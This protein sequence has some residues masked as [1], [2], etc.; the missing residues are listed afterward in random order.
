[1]ASGER[2]AELKPWVVPCFALLVVGFWAM[3]APWPRRV[4]RVERWIDR[5]P[6]KERLRSLDRA[7]VNYA[8]HPVEMARA[9]GLPLATHLAIAGAIHVLARAYGGVLSY[10]D[11]VAV[12]SVANTVS[13]VPISP[14]GWGVGEYLFR[15]L[16]ALAG[17]EPTIGVAV[18]ITF[19]LLMM[20]MGLLGG[21]F[22]LLPSGREVRTGLEPENAAVRG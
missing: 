1:M 19:R 7:L 5:L 21:V 14:S 20:A 10:A 13:A 2:F 16:Y 9:V 18:S 22:L 12:A 3:I 17:D 4:L 8:R 15:E 6:Q 11:H